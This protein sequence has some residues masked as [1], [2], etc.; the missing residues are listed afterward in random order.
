M[1]KKQKTRVILL[2]I[3][4]WQFV[5]LFEIGEWQTAKPFENTI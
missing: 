1:A 5:N 4:E 3:G 2:R